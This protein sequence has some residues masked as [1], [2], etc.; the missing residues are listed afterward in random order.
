M[1]ANIDRSHHAER[2]I[3]LAAKREPRYLPGKHRSG[4]VM[5]DKRIRMG[6]HA[7]VGLAEILGPPL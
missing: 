2:D 4:K 6:R 3:K 7:Q 5:V 1:K